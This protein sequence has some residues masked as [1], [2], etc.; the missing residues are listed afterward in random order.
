[1]PPAACIVAVAVTT[2]TMMASTRSARAGGQSEDEDQDGES[3]RRDGSE[4][5]AT[6]RRADDDAREDHRQFE[7]EQ[8]TLLSAIAGRGTA[9]R[10]RARIEHALDLGFAQQFVGPHQLDDALA[11]AHRLG[12]ELSVDFS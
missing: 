11:G 8:W 6:D 5:G 1:M 3:D 2:V 12:R 4:A 10:H 7:P 9:A